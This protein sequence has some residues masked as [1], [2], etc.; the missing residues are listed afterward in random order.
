MSP[1]FPAARPYWVW[2][3]PAFAIILSILWSRRNRGSSKTDSGGAGETQDDQKSVESD[4]EATAPRKSEISGVLTKSDSGREE[5][6]EIVEKVTL[7]LSAQTVAPVVEENFPERDSVETKEDFH[8]NNTERDLKDEE[9]IKVI[10]EEKESA[11]SQSGEVAESVDREKEKAALSRQ[12]KDIE[13]AENKVQHFQKRKEI[14][15]IV[16][17]EE[18]VILGKEDI[19]SSKVKCCKKEK[20]KNSS[21]KSSESNSETRQNKE[22][23]TAS[24]LE[25]K[26]VKLEL[27]S[28]C[29]N[30]N[31]EE[32]RGSE[33]L[34]ERDSANNSPSEVMLASPSVSGYSET[35]SEVSKNEK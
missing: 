19:D 33:D 10:Q 15:E 28:Q 22:E 23:N 11:I 1:S 17:I 26:L 12:R 21:K 5:I 6:D 34:T 27:G 13:I 8:A 2:S 4:E 25:K 29:N 14:R 30:N 9:V 31:G 35:H 16:S 24:I 20:M 7:N 3:L 18:S 32:N